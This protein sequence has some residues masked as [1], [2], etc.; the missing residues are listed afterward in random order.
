[1]AVKRFLPLYWYKNHRYQ[2]SVIKNLHFPPTR[3]IFLLRKQRHKN[4]KI[5]DCDLLFY[6]H[7][8]NIHIIKLFPLS[9]LFIR[10]FFSYRY[11]VRIKMIRSWVNWDL[12]SASWLFSNFYKTLP[13]IN[14]SVHLVLHPHGIPSIF[15]KFYSWS[16]GAI[17]IP[18]I[19]TKGIH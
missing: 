14:I 15:F 8:W 19:S 16:Q 1:M 11:V 7:I 13:K 2:R 10:I 17:C 4:L 9:I 5:G 18:I 12:N 3:K 6:I